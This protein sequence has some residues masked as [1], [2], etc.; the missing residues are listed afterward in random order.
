MLFRSKVKSLDRER[1]KHKEPRNGQLDG[2]RKDK[3]AKKCGKG[4]ASVASGNR[5]RSSSDE[6]KKGSRA[7]ERRAG[8]AKRRSL[9]HADLFGAESAEDSEEEEEDDDDDDEEEG[10][11]LVR[12]SAAAVKRGSA[13]KRKASELTPSSSE[14]EDGGG[15]EDEPPADEDFSGVDF[16]ALQVDL[17]FDSDPDRKSV[18]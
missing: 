2:G 11:K 15:V 6:A 3:E 4:A 1:D 12:R 13:Y 8:K 17:D 9:S 14:D 18:V 10:E 7:V 5:G 16:S